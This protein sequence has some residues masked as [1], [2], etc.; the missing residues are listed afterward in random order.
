MKYSQTLRRP[1][2]SVLLQ[3]LKDPLKPEEL[4]RMQCNQEDYDY[5][6]EVEGVHFIRNESDGNARGSLFSYTFKN[7]PNGYAQEGQRVVICL[8]NRTVNV[9]L[10][11]V[12]V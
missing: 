6:A 10:K 12:F 5:V 8:Q 1:S 11:C 2:E 9:L 7:N 3:V 4:A